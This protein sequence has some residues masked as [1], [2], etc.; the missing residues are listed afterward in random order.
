MELITNI[1][2]NIDL[3]PT[4]WMRSNLPRYSPNSFPIQFSCDHLDA[5]SS[6][7]SER[8]C[9]Q[10]SDKSS[11]S[12][13]IY[14]HNHLLQMGAKTRISLDFGTIY[15]DNKDPIPKPEAKSST[16]KWSLLKGIK[17]SWQPKL[18]LWFLPSLHFPQQ[19]SAA[20]YVY[21]FENNVL[22]SKTG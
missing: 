14:F 3:L 9:R 17:D 2:E 18:S 7:Y 10:I 5:F 6:F 21:I 8:R 19:I 11:P 15:K 4:Q 13:D 16:T 1:H 22:N 12:R 20:T